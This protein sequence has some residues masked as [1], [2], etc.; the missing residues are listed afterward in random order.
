MELFDKKDILLELCT[1]YLLRDTLLIGRPKVKTFW[2]SLDAT[3]DIA[4]VFF[5]IWLF[6]LRYSEKVR[7]RKR[8]KK[9]YISEKFYE[10][11]ISL[12]NKRSKL[13]SKALDNK[14]LFFEILISSFS[15]I[16][17]VMTAL[18][19]FV[20]GIIVIWIFPHS[21]WIRR[22]TP[23]LSVLSPN[24]GKCGPE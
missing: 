9:R 19:M 24:A 21:Y 13:L 2:G 16:L 5:V 17:I 4:L 11:M 22:D 8:K 20:F 15:I 23:C 7:K 14:T 10:S 18:K 6:T 1:T 3:N 12:T